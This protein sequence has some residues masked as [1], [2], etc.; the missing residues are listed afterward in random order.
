ME[1][2]QRGI[3]ADTCVRK[4]KD[5]GQESPALL[6]TLATIGSPPAQPPAVSCIVGA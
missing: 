6:A 2:T 1:F 4:M 3:R 5:L